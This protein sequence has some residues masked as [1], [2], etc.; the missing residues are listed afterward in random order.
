MLHPLLNWSYVL[1]GR[2]QPPAFPWEQFPPDQCAVV[3]VQRWNPDAWLWVQRDVKLCGGEKKKKQTGLLVAKGVCFGFISACCGQKRRKMGRSASPGKRLRAGGFAVAGTRW[4]LRSSVWSHSQ[5]RVSART[6]CFCHLVALPERLRN[7]PGKPR[8]GDGPGQEGRAGGEVNAGYLCFLS[9]LFPGCY[10]KRDQAL[11][12]VLLVQKGWY[13]HL[14][15]CRTWS[16]HPW[17]NAVLGCIASAAEPAPRDAKSCEKLPRSSCWV[18]LKGFNTCS[19]RGTLA[20]DGLTLLTAKPGGCSQAQALTLSPHLP[21]VEKL[22]GPAVSLS[23]WPGV[24]FGCFKIRI[25]V[26]VELRRVLPLPF[27][28]FS[29]H[30]VISVGFGR[31]GRICFLSSSGVIRINAEWKERALP[32]A[33]FSRAQL[34]PSPQPRPLPG[35][36]RDPSQHMG[37][38]KPL[39]AP[40]QK[41]NWQ[42]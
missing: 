39:P 31:D 10:G 19:S 34:C 14:L 29:S 26:S 25:L 30:I 9:S 17:C 33:R 20:L 7:G 12:G 22:W 28:M 21:R 2:Q 35:P 24:R 40:S 5:P 3:G 37:S 15:A 4:A 6:T 11:Q 8:C 23:L 13:W 16:E 41:W 18:Y 36:L 38:H 27:Y 42:L 1:Q 32:W